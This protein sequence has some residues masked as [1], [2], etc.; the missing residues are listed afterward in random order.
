[1]LAAD[2]GS[3]TGLG[4]NGKMFFTILQGWRHFVT[5]TPQVRELDCPPL[6][7]KAVRT[8]G[9]KERAWRKKLTRFSGPPAWS[10]PHTAGG[11]ALPALTV[12]VR[13]IVWVCPVWL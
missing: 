3:H 5:G 6:Q 4:Q 12:W 11:K 10:P 2:L 1:M 9:L 8:C 7:L 13:E